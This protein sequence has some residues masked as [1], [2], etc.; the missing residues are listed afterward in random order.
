M[1]F[2]ICLLTQLG[3]L[4][5]PPVMCDLWIWLGCYILLVVGEA[6]KRVYS[7]LILMFTWVSVKCQEWARLAKSTHSN[8]LAE[9]FVATPPPFSSPL[10]L[11]CEYYEFL[12]LV[13]R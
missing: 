10:H 13:Y 6:A 1:L 3:G 11:Q 2:Y 5:A 4:F 12:T 9:V 8:S 7:L